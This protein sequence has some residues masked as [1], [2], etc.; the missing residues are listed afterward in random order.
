MSSSYKIKT[1]PQLYKKS[2]KGKIEC[3]R[4]RVE[5]NLWYPTIIVE[6]GEYGGK[7]QTK[8][9]EVK[10]GLNI[11]KKNETTNVEQA[12]K[13]A[14]A[15]W[16]KQRNKGYVE[17]RLDAEAGKETLDA[18]KGGIKPML[19]HD[20]DDHKQK[21]KFPSYVQ[22]KLDGMRCIVTR[23][24]GDVKMWSRERNPILS[25]PHIIEDVKVLLCTID[26]DLFLDGELYL[27]EYSDDFEAIMKA[28]RKQYPTEESKKIQLHLYDTGLI[29]EENT[30]T[31]RIR[32][33]WLDSLPD[34]ATTSIRIVP[35]L[36]LNDHIAIKFHRKEYEKQGYEGLMI[37][38]VD[39]TYKNGRTTSLLKYKIW[40]DAEFKIIDIKKGKD[41]TVIFE[42]V[43]SKGDKF[44]ATKTGDK[45][46]NQKY[47]KKPSLYIGRMLNVRYFKMTKKNKVPK[48][49]QAIYIRVEE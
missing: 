31:Y 5:W 9:N 38:D 47:V 20:Y 13:E 34:W 19:A 36:L 42:C 48:F 11:G 4:I 1:F 49:G 45:N 3:W 33:A 46:E 37:R 26:G 21:V 12:K 41:K 17:D 7:F 18:K 10:V 44:E 28:V 8:K 14:E 16:N 2:A 22:P 15:K 29:N 30:D 23:I 35:T 43:D 40:R 25:C 6:F 32:S 27:H 24:D 39:S